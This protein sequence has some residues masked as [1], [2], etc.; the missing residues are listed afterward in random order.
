MSPRLY[1]VVCAGC[2][3]EVR[4]EVPPLADIKLFCLD[5]Y[6]K[7]GSEQSTTLQVKQ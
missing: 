6:K 5:Y 7:Q 2:G 4:M 1:K 3:K